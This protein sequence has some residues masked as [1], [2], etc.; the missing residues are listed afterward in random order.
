[1][2]LTILFLLIFS[3]TLLLAQLYISPSEHSDSYLYARDRLIYV[4]KEINLYK[5]D[6]AETE[7]SLYLRKSAQLLQGDKTGNLNK[8]DGLLSVYQRGTSNAFD[9]N[10]WGL[11]VLVIG[12]KG[13]LNDYLYDLLSNTDSRKAKLISALDGSSSPLSISNRWIYTYAGSN[14]SNWQYL[15]DHFDLLPGEGFSMKGVN[16]NN[17][18][19]I[20]S[21][22]INPG[23]SQL[24]DYRG[25]PNDGIISLPI[26]IDQILLLGNPYPSALDLDRF[27]FDNTASTGIAYFWDSKKD[28]NTHYVSEYEGGYGIY[29]PGTGIYLPP[30]FKKGF[31]NEITGETGRIYPRSKMPIAQGFMVIGKKDGEIIF[32]NSQRIYQKEKPEVSVFKSSESDIQSFILNIEMDSTYIRQLALAFRNDSTVDEDHAMDA[33]NMDSNLDD[34]SWIIDNEAFLINVRPKLDE[35]LIPLNIKLSKASTINFSISNISNFDPDRIFI[36]DSKD[37]LYFGIKTGS[38][39]INLVEG[40]YKDRFFVSFIEKLPTED[41][42]HDEPA[43]DETPEN[44]GFEKKP[45]IVLLNTIDIF[46]NNLQEQLEIKI[47]YDTELSNIKIYDLN[48]KLFLNHNF[49]AKEKEFNFS[50]G[51]LS[52]ALYIVKVKTTDNKELTKKIGVKH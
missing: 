38:L 17:S 2:K 5:N 27:L 11:P 25:T 30:V 29:S 21:E 36:Y 23:S 12:E 34:F 28:G 19:L 6:K 51:N 50:T 15:G 42:Q 3:P 7:A 32:Q 35:E 37:D 49:K 9:Y 14:Y 31:S 39:K 4:E 10:Y 13:Q 44:S 1:M 52:N 18:S 41:T 20:E 16:G 33:R 48:A 46:Q 26:K 8:G 24:Y 47:L 22:T 45:P 43:R 40:D